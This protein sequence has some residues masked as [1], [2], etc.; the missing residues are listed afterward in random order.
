M[1]HPDGCWEALGGDPQMGAS[2]ATAAGAYERWRVEKDKQVTHS[3][4]TGLRFLST[5]MH[6][7]MNVSPNTVVLMSAPLLRLSGFGRSCLAAITKPRTFLKEGLCI[8]LPE[9]Y[10]RR[11]VFLLVCRR[12][13]RRRTLRIPNPNPYPPRPESHGADARN[14]YSVPVQLRYSKNSRVRI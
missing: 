13:M 5:V 2:R 6:L 4:I 1:W 9:Y 11:G 12:N 7:I 8:L 3:L 14:Y 10:V